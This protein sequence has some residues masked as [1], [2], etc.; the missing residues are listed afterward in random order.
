MVDEKAAT[1]GAGLR[2]C[3]R[4]VDRSLIESVQDGGVPALLSLEGMG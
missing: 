3:G 4:A 1:P 2:G